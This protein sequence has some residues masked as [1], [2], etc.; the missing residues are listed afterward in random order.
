MEELVSIMQDIR[1]L[2]SEMNDNLYGIRNDIRDISASG[3]Y[4]LRDV[5]SELNNI[6]IG[7]RN[8]ETII[9]LK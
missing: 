9:D 4:S 6:D 7:I 1:N 2:L 8:L 5:Y 3:V